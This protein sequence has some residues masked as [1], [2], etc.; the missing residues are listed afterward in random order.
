MEATQLENKI[1][2]L[3]KKKNDWHSLKKDHKKFI[4]NKKSVLKIQQR[5]KSEEINKIVLSSNDEK[6]IHSIDLIEI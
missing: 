4:K 1:K 6:R 2:N 5:F 3:D